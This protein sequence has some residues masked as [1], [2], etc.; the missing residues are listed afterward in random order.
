MAPKPAAAAPKATTPAAAP[1]K[2]AAKKQAATGTKV[3]P[4]KK[5][6]TVANP[7]FPSRPKSTRIGGDLRPKG[8]DLSRFVRW[9]K[10]IRVQRQKKIL[11]QRLKVPP[12]INQFTRTLDKNNAAELL[13]LLVKYQPETSQAK[14]TRLEAQAVAIAGKA[15]ASS[16]SPPP[17]TL[18][19]GL[20]HV[21]T[22]V[23]QKKA[24]LVVI[25]HDVDPIELVIWLPALCRKMDVPFCIIKGKAR[26]GTLTH[27]KTC[28]VLALTAV[29]KEDE[30]R[31][32]SLQDGFRA[33]F[34]DAVERKWGGG[35]MGLKTQA[36]LLK[37]QQLIE[38]EL[39][40]KRD[41][42]R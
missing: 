2:S 5:T 13:K 10:Y 42:Q 23:E 34:N 36:K 27:K 26:L 9:P 25:A 4:K 38:A 31:L 22:L 14:Q 20:K 1:P 35:L 41:A 19:Y 12:A 39:A 15:A 6:A 32:K 18:K 11:L 30:A 24:R 33:Q 8:R 29:G 17:P 16:S 37:R 28:A 7:L 21:T 40:K 3:A